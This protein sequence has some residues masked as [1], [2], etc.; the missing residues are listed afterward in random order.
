MFRHSSG[1]PAQPGDT[2]QHTSGETLVLQAEIRERVTGRPM[3]VVTKP[4]GTMPRHVYP[5]EVGL[6]HEVEVP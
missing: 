1:R 5:G 3:V 4:D 6:S 2:V